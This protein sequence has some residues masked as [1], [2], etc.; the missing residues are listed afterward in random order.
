MNLMFYYS[1]DF[2]FLQNK[3]RNTKYTRANVLG[4]NIKIFEMKISHVI[5][6]RMREREMA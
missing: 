4:I 3:K 5:L 6:N 2:F 1:Q